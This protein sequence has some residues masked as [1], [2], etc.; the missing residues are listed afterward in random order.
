MDEFLRS[1]VMWPFKAAACLLVGLATAL[2]LLFMPKSWLARLSRYPTL[3]PNGLT[4]WGIVL[5]YGGIVL[6][7]KGQLTIGW[8]VWVMGVIFDVMDGR[9]AKAM[10]QFHVPRSAR[11]IRIGK[12]FDPA[13]DKIK[14]LPP[15]AALAWYAYLSGWPIWPMIAF[16]AIGTLMRPPFGLLN[17]WQRETSA[18]APGK[19]KAL[20]Q[21]S[22]L[23]ASAPLLL[24]WYRDPTVPNIFMSVASVASALSVGSR[25]RTTPAIDRWLKLL[26]KRYFSHDDVL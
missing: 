20:F 26:G 25:F 16:D 19:V 12:V 11:S 6:A 3:G 15:I 18:E 7:T 13:A 24:A 2:P 14:Y 22:G 1:D 5:F 4:A 17:R 23:I 10:K 21:A 8:I 9:S